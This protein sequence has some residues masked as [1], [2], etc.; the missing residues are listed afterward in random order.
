MSKTNQKS[1][2][3]DDRVDDEGSAGPGQPRT[4]DLKTSLITRRAPACP[5][6]QSFLAWVLLVSIFLHEAGKFQLCYTEA[7]D[8]V[9]RDYEASTESVC[10]DPMKI[11][12]TSHRFGPGCTEARKILNT[13]VFMAANRC[14]IE[15]HMIYSIV[16]FEHT[17]RNYVFLAITVLLV[18]WVLWLAKGY[19]VDRAK[20]TSDRESRQEMIRAFGGDREKARSAST[21]P[22]DPGFPADTPS[23]PGS[24]MDLK[25]WL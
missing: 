17:P 14:W 25:D 24:I 11:A 4:A 20:I 19:C 10:I 7:S 1:G 9:V 12:R 16:A 6:V 3:T 23:G 21:G 15:R 18:M 13:G 2:K 22:T 5:N 8:L